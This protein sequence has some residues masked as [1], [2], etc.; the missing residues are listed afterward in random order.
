MTEKEKYLA[1]VENARKMLGETEKEVE[2]K[3]AVTPD[4]TKI[5]KTEELR[6]IDNFLTETLEKEGVKIDKTPTTSPKTPSQTLG[7]IKRE[8]PDDDKKFAERLQ[9]QERIIPQ[10]NY[11]TPVLPPP[12]AKKKFDLVPL[13][14]KGECYP[15]KRDKI[16]VY[17][18]TAKDENLVN[19]INLYR[20]GLII[21][22]ILRNTIADSDINPDDLIEA[23]INAILLFLRTTAYGTDY[24]ITTM[25]PYNNQEFVTTCDL[26]QIKYKDFNLKGDENGWFDYTTSTGELIKFAYPDRGELRQFYK[27]VANVDHYTVTEKLNGMITDLNNLNNSNFPEIDNNDTLKINNAVNII[28]NI[29]HK[30]SSINTS[31]LYLDVFTANMVMYIRSINGEMNRGYVKEYVDNML[32]GDARKFRI[33]AE[34]NAPDLDY[35]ISVTI[36]KGQEHEGEVIEKTLNIDNS[37]FL[38]VTND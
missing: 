26:S 28:T 33:Y 9:K 6:V 4:S 37:L 24:P 8:L 32:A 16:A 13:P 14:S 27:Q 1:M 36:P 17:Y 35:T 25:N 18:L 7:V 21:D 12:T 38:N 31:N 34:K 3:R 10:K 11:E 29:K 5:V 2:A 23:D 20:D 22:A 19:S 30:I 15:H